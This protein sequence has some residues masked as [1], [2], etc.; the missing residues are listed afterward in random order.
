MTACIESRAA[1]PLIRLFSPS[2]NGAALIIKLIASK[3]V[4]PIERE[5]E[6][7]LLTGGL[8]NGGIHVLA[9]SK[10][11]AIAE[12]VSASGQ[13]AEELLDLFQDELRDTRT[14]I[15][16]GTAPIMASY[17]KTQHKVRSPVN[18]EALVG[19][20]IFG[21]AVANLLFG[22]LE[23]GELISL[24]FSALAALAYVAIRRAR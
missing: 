10:V 11:S 6:M 5:H 20:A 7:S 22:R 24:A 9:T 12:V 3:E 19:V 15:R 17:V 2:D 16:T 14:Q 18:A 21:A 23:H 8:L 13:H 4:K 1:T